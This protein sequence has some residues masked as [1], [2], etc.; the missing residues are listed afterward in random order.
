MSDLYETDILAW[1]EQQADLL[2]QHAQAQERGHPAYMPNAPGPDWSNIIEEIESV[3]R[4]ELRACRSHLLQAFLHDLKAEAWPLSRDVPHWRSE[5]RVARIN[6]ADAYAPSMRKDIDLADLYSKALRALPDTVD[7]TPP[8]PVPPACPSRWTSCSPTDQ[9]AAGANATSAH[10][11]D[12]PS[13]VPLIKK[14][15]R[16]RKLGSRTFMG[17]RSHVRSGEFL[18]LLVPS[19]HQSSRL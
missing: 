13:F 19:V 18:N 6:A 12:R 9:G 8:L 5:A 11:A 16:R 17:S 2:R 15:V 3:G 10:F 7:G 4:S 14:Q 1:A